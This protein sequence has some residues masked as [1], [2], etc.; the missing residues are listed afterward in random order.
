MLLSQSKT[1]A[2]HFPH[3]NGRMKG[4]SMIPVVPILYFFT[5]RCQKL[6]EKH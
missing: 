3:K 2:S 5:S 4:N 6:Q 1:L